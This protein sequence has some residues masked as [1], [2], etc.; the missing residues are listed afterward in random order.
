MKGDVK[1][2]LLL[3]QLLIELLAAGSDVWSYGS[4][5]HLPLRQTCLLVFKTFD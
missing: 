5:W 3:T 1:S 4:A 2:K